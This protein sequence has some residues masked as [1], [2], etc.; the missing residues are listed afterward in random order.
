[1]PRRSTQLVAIV[2]TVVALVGAALLAPAVQQ[3]R[4]DLRL[5]Y[6][7]QGRENTQVESILARA[8]LGSF[9]GIAVNA[10]W[11][12]AEQQKQAGRLFDANDTA[13]LITTLQPRFPQVWAF[14]AWNMAYNISVLTHTPGERWDWVQKGIH[15]LRDEGIPENPEA[16][17][18]YR[19]LSWIYFHKVGQWSDDMHWYYKQRLA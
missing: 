3:Q 6:D 5:V 17:R 11:Y 2:I 1:M 15:L 13:Q 16:V 18:L 4:Q 10:L 12:H 14:N 8:A 9:R 7:V 19:E